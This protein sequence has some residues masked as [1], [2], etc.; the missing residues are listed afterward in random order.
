MV[1]IPSQATMALTL[2]DA[3]RG[4]DSG[5]VLDDYQHSLQTATRAERAGADRELVTAAL[6]HDVGKAITRRNHGR[7]AAEI[8]AGAVR[9]EIVWLVSVHQ[10]FTAVGLDNGRRRRA[11]YRHRL[12]PRYALARRFVDEWDLPSRDPEYDTYPVEHFT[13][14]V[15]AVFAGSPVRPR[16][17]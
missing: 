3:L 5:L 14:Q 15:H 2:L 6:L 13:D 11:R 12:H 7:V 8:L 9:P 4:R 1:E 17:G 16:T 10:D